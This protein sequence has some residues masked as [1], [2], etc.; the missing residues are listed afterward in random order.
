MPFATSAD[1]TRIAYETAGSGPAL[2]IVDGAMCYRESGPSRPLSAALSPYFAVTIYD[3][4][5]RGESGDTQP[6]AVDREIEDLQAVIKAVGG[7]VYLYGASSGG[8]LALLTAARTGEVKRVMSYEAPVIVDAQHQAMTQ[9]DINETEAM[10]AAGRRSDAIKKFMRFVDVP[11]FALLMMSMMGVFKKIGVVA[12][13]L[14]NDYRLMFP[15][16]Q[17]KPLPPA[18]FDL[19]RVPVLIADG[20][21][22]PPWMRSGQRA[23]ATAVSGADYGTVEGQTHI[24]NPKAQLPLIREFFA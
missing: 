24:V 19:I 17:G 23:L 14:P 6:Y 8:M 10:V 20:G 2:I 7:P 9:A 1:G 13:T 21:K 11:G 16:Q 3:R 22:S 12:H 15:Y 5:S 4:R 18:P